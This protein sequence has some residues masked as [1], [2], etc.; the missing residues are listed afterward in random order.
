MFPKDKDDLKKMIFNEINKQGPEADLNHIDVSK[1]TDFSELFKHSTF[2][3]DISGW[4]VSEVMNMRE[5]FRGCSSFDQ[6]LSMWDVSNVVYG[7]DYIFK[8]C[9]CSEEH[10]LQFNK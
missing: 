4:D 9:P 7:G 6:D 5:M 1:I 3:G 10:K 2:S 8:G